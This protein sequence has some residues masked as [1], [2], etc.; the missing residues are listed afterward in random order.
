MDISLTVERKI[1]KIH[2]GLFTSGILL[3]VRIF[4]PHGRRG[5]P[6]NVF[7]VLTNQRPESDF[8]DQSAARVVAVLALST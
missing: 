6:L 7:T 4:P 3:S 5:D 2:L 1:L 8:I